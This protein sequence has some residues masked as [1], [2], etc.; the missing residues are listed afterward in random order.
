[1]LFWLS[2]LI[3]RNARNPHIVSNFIRL[4]RHLELFSGIRIID[5]IWVDFSVDIVTIL[6][7][8]STPICVS[9]DSFPCN[10]ITLFNTVLSDDCSVDRQTRIRAVAASPS[11]LETVGSESARAAAAVRSRAVALGTVGGNCLA[12][13]CRLLVL[14]SGV[15]NWY[16]QWI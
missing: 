6:A 7:S 11:K 10:R 2:V 13:A 1:M 16:N 15:K 9:D 4:A 8:S 12:A 3:V 14:T 5:C